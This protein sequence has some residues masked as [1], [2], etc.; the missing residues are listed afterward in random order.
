MQHNKK[1]ALF[2]LLLLLASGL[3]ATQTA[4]PVYADDNAQV[5]EAKEAVDANQKQAT[6][7]QQ[8]IQTQENQITELN[9]QISNKTVAIDKST[10]QL[11]ASQ[12]KLT[13]LNKKITATKMDV[14]AREAAMKKRLVALQKQ[15]EKSALGNVYADFVLSG[16]DFSEVLSR[17]M[18]VKKLSNTNKLALQTL[19]NTQARLTDLRTTKQAQQKK[20]V[21]AKAQLETDNA[22]L[23]KAKAD[24]DAKQTQLQNQ[25]A[26]TQAASTD[27]QDQLKKAQEAQAALEAANAAEKQRQVE[28]IQAQAQVADQA[29]ATP[30]AMPSTANNSA[31]YK[32]AVA[33]VLSDTA[34]NNKIIQD[35]LQYLGVPYVWGGTTPAGFDCS[36]LIYYCYKLEGRTI[37]RV[38]QGQSTQGQY[39][40]IGN[41]QPGDLVF[42]G[43][44]GTAHH[45][46]LY[47]GNGQYIHAPQPGET[48]KIGSLAYYRPDFGRRL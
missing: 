44:V 22:Q 27:L 18:A 34:A 21:A 19:Q 12:K 28:T 9:N 7:L 24:A 15:S 29:T 13:K 33:S 35:A 20:I 26:T 25:L 1:I 23:A 5:S 40:S 16:R 2:G 14:K 4:A 31:T 42:W 3:G 37:P 17:A 11:T 8:Q 46:G 36:G 30:A 47:I 32:Q 48:V 38:S 6:A 41:L 43:G 39:V 10:Q 45:V